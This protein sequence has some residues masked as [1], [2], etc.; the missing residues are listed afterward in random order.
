MSLNAKENTI[1]FLVSEGGDKS[2]PLE[3]GIDSNATWGLD[4]ALGEVSMFPG[5]PPEGFDVALQ[6]N[7][8]F[9]NGTI[10]IIWSNKDLKPKSDSVI[11]SRLYYFNCQRDSDNAKLIIN[12]LNDGSKPY[13]DSVVVLDYPIDPFFSK[14][15]SA[16]ENY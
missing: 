16:S 8:T 14:N 12:R 11:F 2:F 1:K 3:C 10:D 13:I 4:T 5:H 15:L 9:E 7:D 6:F